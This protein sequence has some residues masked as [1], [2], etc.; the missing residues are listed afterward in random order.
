MGRG[1]VVL[2]QFGGSRKGG[3]GHA[4]AAG[5]GASRLVDA[6]KWAN[7]SGSNIHLALIFYCSPEYQKYHN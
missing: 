6:E 5:G 1:R 4:G 3:E 7:Q 2:G